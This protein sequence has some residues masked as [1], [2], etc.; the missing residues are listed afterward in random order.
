MGTA[1]A[2]PLINASVAGLFLALWYYGFY[3]ALMESYSPVDATV[4]AF[5]WPLIAVVAIRLIS[6]ATAP[7]LRIFQWAMLLVSFAGVAVISINGSMNSAGGGTPEILWACAAALGSGLYM[8]F[9]IN[10][11]KAIE[12]GTGLS[13]QGSVF[14]AISVSNLVSLAAV[15]VSLGAFHQSLDFSNVDSTALVICLIIGVGIYLVAEVSWTWA[16]QAHKSLT[17]ASLPYYSP[18]VSIILLGFLFHEPISIQAAFGLGLVLVA[19]LALSRRGKAQSPKG[20]DANQT[21]RS[22]A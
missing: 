17:L 10:A 20:E 5:S 19:N 18:A 16:M 12:Q 9:A 21:E 13:S 1:L 6:P 14:V 8:P 2:M 22:L 3:R 7:P 4:I 15:L 11:G